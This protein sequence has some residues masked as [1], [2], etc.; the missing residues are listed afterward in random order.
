[1]ILSKLRWK[2]CGTEVFAFLLLSGFGPNA[3]PIAEFVGRHLLRKIVDSA[4]LEMLA[5]RSGTALNSL[6]QR[7]EWEEQVLHGQIC[8]NN[9]MNGMH[10]LAAC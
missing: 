1:M 7:N 5:Q 9:F 2:K 8:K 3:Q 4:Q 6:A 10:R